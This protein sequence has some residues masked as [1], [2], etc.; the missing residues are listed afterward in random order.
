MYTYEEMHQER[1]RAHAKHGDKSAEGRPWNDPSM[2]DILVE[3]VGEVA[4]V[5]NEFAL[6]NL[7]E[8]EAR[9]ELRKELVQC[10][11][12]VAAFIDNVEVDSP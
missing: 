9:A 7:T 3:E 2:R 8:Q 11:A 12:M 4:R 1:I 5:F 6:G 10:G